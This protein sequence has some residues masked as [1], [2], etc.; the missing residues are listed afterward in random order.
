[1]ARRDRAAPARAR[2]EALAED[3]R[4]ETFRV[5]A[6]ETRPGALWM[7]T[8]ARHLRDPLLRERWRTEPT[9]I[10]E[11]LDVIMAKLDEARG[12]ALGMLPG[13]DIE[14]LREQGFL[15]PGE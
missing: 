15:R 1:M 8:A 4:L 5:Q 11:S 13:E 10:D 6:N 9:G 7:L 3:E 12:L 14:R 2:D